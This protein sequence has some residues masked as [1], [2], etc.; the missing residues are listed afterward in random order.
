MR[1]DLM[2]SL[3]GVAEFEELWNRRTTIEVD[4]E[5]IDMLSRE[6]LVRAKKTQLDEDW[7]MIRH[8]LERSYLT[9]SGQAPAGQIEFWLRELRTPGMLAA[10]TLDHPS[11]ARRMAEARS[12]VRAAISGDLSEISRALAEEEEDERRKDRVYREPL[13][14]ELE[15]FR[16][17]KRL[18]GPGP[19]PL[20]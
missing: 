3:R 18:A 8:L 19:A 13:K 1:I 9:A 12:A 2:S 16:R 7:P 10:V 20:A 14:L 17:A 6:D 5:P 15:E 4:G 11:T